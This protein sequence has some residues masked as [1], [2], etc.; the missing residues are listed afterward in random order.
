MAQ[1]LSLLAATQAGVSPGEA[2]EALPPDLT[3]LSLEQLMALRVGGRAPQDPDDALVDDALPNAA[4]SPVLAG[5]SKPAGTPGQGTNDLPADLTALSLLQLMNL[6]VRA[7]EPEE[8]PEVA[9]DAA[10]EV[11]TVAAVALVQD[12][13]DADSEPA[14]G[15]APEA[16]D[17]GG[18][19]F[20][21]AELGEVD[22]ELPQDLA[23]ILALEGDDPLAEGDSSASRRAPAMPMARTRSATA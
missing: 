12:Q 9:E 11:E 20:S 5:V 4:A 23:F 8:E 17:G 7:P 15:P 21:A 3:A 16:N 22:G 6:P 2:G 18:A 13:E 19:D 10:D 14:E 1:P